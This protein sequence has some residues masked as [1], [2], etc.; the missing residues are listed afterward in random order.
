VGSVYRRKGTD[1]LWI[2]YTQHGRTIRES[3][4]TDN[5]VEARRMLRNREGLVAKGLPVTPDVGRV[6][7]DEAV[8][9]LLN[10]Y[11]LNQRKSTDDTRRRIE[12][13]I[14][15]FFGN[16][17]MISITTADLRAFVAK[18]QK[19]GVVVRRRRAGK[20]PPGEDAIVEVWLPV[21]AAELNRELTTLKR[22]FSLA[23]QA[24]KLHYKPH[25]PMLRENNVRKGFFERD[26]Y[27][28]VLKHLP[29]AM[30]PIV[31][32]AYVTGWRINSEVLPL[33][34]RQVDL[35][36]GEVRLDPGTT[37]N[38]EGRVFYLTPEL[39]ALLQ[40]QRDRA[41]EIQRDLSMIVQHVFF[42]QPAMKDGSL[43]M[44]A[45]KGISGHGFYQAWRRARSK[46]GC[47]GSIPHDFRRTAIRSMVRAG[48]P[49]RVAMA[50]SGHKTRSVFDRYNIVSD[51]DLRAAT[52]R[53]SAVSSQAR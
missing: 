40:A 22:M 3:T 21:S 10:D 36:A 19:D 34:W 4:E 25:F 29:E 31:T 15:P 16:R 41:D 27:L 28:A 9:D 32:F 13:H 45:G 20:V 1:K 35:A 44:R 23:V 46:A 52:A 43:G 6:T 47:P 11:A 2:K 8:A 49:E 30:R 12:K 24:A 42:H 14:R 18:R 38:G 7:F 51:G 26:Q 48:I 50:L 33:Q 5:M 53:L 37:K 39:Q 17:R